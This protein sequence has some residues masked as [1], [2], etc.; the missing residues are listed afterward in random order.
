M[1]K[2]QKFQLKFIDNLELYFFMN[3]FRKNSRIKKSIKKYF[4]LTIITYVEK[5]I[6]TSMKKRGNL[7]GVFDPENNLVSAAFF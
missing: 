3:L 6:K 7:V 4:S 2:S 1:K 5:L